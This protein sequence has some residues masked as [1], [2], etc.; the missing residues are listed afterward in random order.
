MAVDVNYVMENDFAMAAYLVPV[1][2]TM[3]TRQSRTRVP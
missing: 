1:V 3:I 2:A